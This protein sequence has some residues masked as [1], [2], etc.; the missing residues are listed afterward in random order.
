MIV[1]MQENKKRFIDKAFLLT[2]KRFKGNLKMEADFNLWDTAK[3][4]IKITPRSTS[5]MGASINSKMVKTGY[6]CDHVY[7]VFLQELNDVMGDLYGDIQFTHRGLKYGIGHGFP[8]A[9]VET[10]CECEDVV[11]ISP[12][13]PVLE[14]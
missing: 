7:M 11:L 6:C 3:W 5:L 10:K 12:T 8:L 2:N 1:F 13:T 9:Y 4:T 14:Y